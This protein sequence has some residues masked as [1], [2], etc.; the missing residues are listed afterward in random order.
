M[1]AALSEFQNKKLE[2]EAYLNFVVGLEKGLVKIEPTPQDIMELT[3]TLKA[4]VY[5][6]L[7]N[8]V[9]STMR[10][11]LDEFFAELSQK[12]VEINDCSEK[13]QLQVLKLWKKSSPEKLAPV[14]DVASQMIE[15]AFKRAGESFSGNLDSREIRRV[16]DLYG[17]DNS[18]TGGRTDFLLAVKNNRNDLAHGIKSFSEVGRDTTHS[19]IEEAY[20]QV[21][22]VLTTTIAS[23]KNHLDTALYLSTTP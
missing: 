1:Q 20:R 23:F 14:T 17:I 22:F 3:K 4:S 8:L 12:N 18:L 7:Y 11:V 21:D 15:N 6:L 10:N 5:L 2:I 9:E 13:L 16:S 19:D